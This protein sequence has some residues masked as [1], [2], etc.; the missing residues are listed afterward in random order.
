MT[1]DNMSAPSP[2]P[3]LIFS[4]AA[5]QFSSSFTDLLPM[6]LAYLKNRIVRITGGYGEKSSFARKLLLATVAAAGIVGPLSFGLLL[7]TEVRAQ[8]TS[9]APVFSFD[10]ASVKPDHLDGRHINLSYDNHGLRASG[11]S[12][13][14]LIAA[15]Y[16]VN[17]FQVSG[18]PGWTD[19][20]TYEIQAKIDEP[21]VEALSKLST[22]QRE[23]QHR[24]MVQSLLADRFK[25][26]LSHSNKEGPIYAL[27]SMKNGP[28]FSRSTASDDGQNVSSNNG[29]VTVDATIGDF[30]EWLS[31]VVG[32]KVV[33]KTGLAG[34]YAFK[35]KYDRRKRLMVADNDDSSGP[36]IFTAL[37]DQLGLKL[38]SQKGPVDTLIIDSAEKPSPN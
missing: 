34:K 38:E 17:D 26:K 9:P 14:G 22:A 15:A 6:R 11:V 7:S 35:L 3:S 27:V 23:E 28:K 20:E 8:T 2:V 33:D 24:L 12:L 16:N 4:S 36:S 30:A 13:K 21:V 32:R 31:G 1:S 18:G 5:A 10:V 29:D 19:S 37:Q 25:L